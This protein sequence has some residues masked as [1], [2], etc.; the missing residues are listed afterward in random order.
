MG[1]LLNGLSRWVYVR[2]NRTNLVYHG[3]IKKYSDSGQ[4]RE[5]LMEDVSVYNENSKHLYDLEQVYFSK[6]KFDFSI[7]VSKE[8]VRS[9]GENLNE[10]LPN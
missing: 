8:E 5:M 1:A 7:E 9:S 6:D 10:D 3:Y 4:E 2:D